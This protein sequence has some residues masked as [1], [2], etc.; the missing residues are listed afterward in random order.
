MFRYSIP[1]SGWIIL[2]FLSIP[3]L[4]IC[5]LIDRSLDCF[6]LVVSMNNTVVSTGVSVFMWTYVLTTLGCVTSS[7]IS[8]NTMFNMFK[9]IQTDFQIGWTIL[10]FHHQCMRVPVFPSC[11][12][13]LLFSVFFILAVLVDVKWNLIAVLISLSSMANDIED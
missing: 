11:Y 8:G 1:F 12:Q 5:L 3:H 7:V 6:C 2:R 10:Q 13:F 4:F 9:N